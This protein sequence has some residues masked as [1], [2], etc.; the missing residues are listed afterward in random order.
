[1]PLMKKISKRFIGFGDRFF[2]VLPGFGVKLNQAELDFRPREYLAIAFFSLLFWT[3]MT[4]A[5]L[6]AIFVIAKLPQNFIFTII[7]VSIVIGFLSFFYIIFY[8]SLIITRKVKDLEK[9]LFFG[10]RHLLVQVR[11][12][13]PLFDGLVSV[14]SGKYGLMSKELGQ[15]TKKI[16]TGLEQTFALE[17]L[18]LKNPSLHFRRVIWQI[19]SA[20]KTG[21]D[22]GNTLESIVHNLSEEQKVAI[23]RYGSQLNPLAMMYMMMAV[24]IPSLGITFLI[25]F[26][27][28]SGIV[29]TESLFLIILFALAFFQFTFIGIVKSRRPAIEL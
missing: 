25:I 12:G 24:I 1:M 8:P 23:R 4:F 6:L 2:K 28:F 7:P 21:A 18:A 15:C 26:S 13:V 9:N 3:S 22:L 17:E 10:I 27:S 20:I 19:T 11:S 29:V 5:L 16:S 14:A